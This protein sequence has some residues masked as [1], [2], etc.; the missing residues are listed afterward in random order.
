LTRFSPAVSAAP[1]HGQVCHVGLEALPLVQRRDQ[2]PDGV[3]AHLADLPAVLADQVDVVGVA[4]QV[5]GRR[6]VVQV[7]VGDK[8]EVVQ[9][10][11][12]A[13]DRRDVDA[14]G[15]FL[16]AC[17]DL[18]RRRV[19]EVGYRLKDELALRRDP[20]AARPQLLIPGARQVVLHAV[21]FSSAWGPGG[22]PGAARLSGR[23]AITA[24]HSSP[25]LPICVR[26]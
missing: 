13:V 26:I 4:G 12:G 3:R 11:E 10:L 17:R 24:S 18:L 15:G 9:E 1:E 5:V 25:T 21:E 20:V 22:R 19:V 2:R 8:A 16:D 23:R 14:S 6:A 7:R